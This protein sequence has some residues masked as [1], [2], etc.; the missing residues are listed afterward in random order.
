MTPPLKIS[1]VT[2]SFNQAEYIGRTI[3]SVLAQDDPHFEHIIMDGGSTDG[4]VDIL[5][6]YDHLYWV[7]APDKGQSDALNRGFAK[8]TGQII[9]WV[10]SDDLYAPG[11]FRAVR[12]Y[13]EAHPLVRILTGNQVRIDEHDTIIDRRPP[14][15][16][17]ARMVSPWRWSGGTSVFQVGTM[18]FREVYDRFGPLDE[19]FHYGMDYDFFLRASREYPIH[20]LAVDIGHFRIQPDAKTAE[21]WD[22]FGPDFKRSL[23]AHFEA[24]YAPW[25]VAWARGQLHLYD[26]QRWLTEA[27]EAH[28]EGRHEEYRRLFHR[29]MRRNPAVLAAY[30]HLCFRLKNLIGDDAYAT[31]RSRYRSAK[32]A[33]RSRG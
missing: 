1:V 28:E 7:S 14:E 8:S 18:F 31:L 3:D 24:E 19:S 21:G 4:T 17:R 23:I 10:N 27:M 2:P 6:S 15:M 25:R 22:K 33:I 30:P 32:S 12:D 16:S 20:Q 13:I 9:G 5:R 11:A 29:A 26:A